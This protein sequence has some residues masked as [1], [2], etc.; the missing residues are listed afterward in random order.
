LVI[1]LSDNF[2]DEP[3]KTGSC[4]TQEFVTV[5]EISSNNSHVMFLKIKD[6]ILVT[7]YKTLRMDF[8]VWMAA[9]LGSWR[10]KIS[11][12]RWPV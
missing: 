8:M 10:G 7:D 2:A 1:S 11:A 6:F 4:F 3:I 12:E 5:A 9:V